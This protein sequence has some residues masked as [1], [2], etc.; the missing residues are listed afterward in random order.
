MVRQDT[1]EGFKENENT[2][3]HKQR[4]KHT[5]NNQSAAHTKTFLTFWEFNHFQFWLGF[6]THHPQLAAAQVRMKWFQGKN[7][8]LHLGRHIS[9]V[10][11]TNHGGKV[12]GG[13]KGRGGYLVNAAAYTSYLTM[14]NTHTH[15][16]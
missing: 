13:G 1:N 9:G 16:Y 6:S 5:T 11:H 7:V 2:Q 4:A 12:W 14:Y 15:I 10:Y 8:D 3:T